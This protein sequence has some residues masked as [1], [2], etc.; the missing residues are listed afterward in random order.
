MRESYDVLYYACE[1]ITIFYLF[2]IK[3]IITNLK[4]VY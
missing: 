1:I 3:I 4:V 2:N